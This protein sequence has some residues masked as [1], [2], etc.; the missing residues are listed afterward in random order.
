M[1]KNL[2]VFITGATSGFGEACA[3]RFAQDGAQLIITGRREQR[4]FD[5]ANQLNSPVHA[6]PLDLRDRCTIE[7]A[8]EDLPLEFR[9]VDVLINSAGLALGIEPAHQTLLDEWE[10]MIDT[11]CR[12]LVTITRALLPGMVERNRGHI[13]NIGSVAGSYPY[14]GGNVYGATK[15]FVHQ[16]SLNLKADL[17]GTSIRVTCIEPG[18]AET[19]FSLVRLKNLE[20]AKKVYEGMQP[21]SALDIANAI[22]WCTTLP[23]HVNVNLMELMPVTQSFS[24]FSINRS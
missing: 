3:K 4:L 6:I 17:L 5:L 11:N 22:H 16:F 10:Q 21:L 12:G 8:V 13:F 9:E 20:K 18:M 1:K 23:D 19:E 24:P 7:K 14:P 15:A 2:T